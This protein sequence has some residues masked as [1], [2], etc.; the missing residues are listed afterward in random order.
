MLVLAV[1][2]RSHTLVAFTTDPSVTASASS[3][4]LGVHLARSASGGDPG[5]GGHD[6]DVVFRRCDQSNS[7]CQFAYSTN[8]CRTA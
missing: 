7:T 4:S 3:G 5:S 8:P 2:D 6:V 1:G